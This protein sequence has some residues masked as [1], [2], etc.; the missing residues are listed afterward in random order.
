MSNNEAIIAAAFGI[1]GPQG[2]RTDFDY[3]TALIEASARI[4]AEAAEPVAKDGVFRDPVTVGEYLAAIDR[5]EDH[6]AAG[7]GRDGGKIIFGTLRDAVQEQAKEGG[8]PSGR[9][10][11]TI[12]NY[13]KTDEVWDD[14]IQRTERLK[15]WDGSWNA[16][17]R[18]V[19]DT[20][21]ALKGHRVK[22][23]LEMVAMSSGD[24]MRTIRHIE[25]LGEDADY[26]PQ[27][28][29]RPKPR[30]QAAGAR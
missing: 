4:R 21:R 23:W 27:A 2:E 14:E 26:D 29:H 18:A 15:Q 19:A 24:Y 9:V 16:A 1:I 22:M 20:A 10:L 3:R 8:R 6:V 11:V 12:S 30:R 17:S 28:K 7:R 13:N 25:D 5:V